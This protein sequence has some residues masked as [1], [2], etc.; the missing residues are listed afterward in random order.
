M[1]TIHVNWRISTRLKWKFH[2]SYLIKNGN[3]DCKIKFGKTTS[4]SEPFQVNHTFSNKRLDYKWIYLANIIVEELIMSSG[5]NVTKYFKLSSRTL[6]VFC[7]IFISRRLSIRT[8]THNCETLRYAKLHKFNART[9]DLI[10]RLPACQ[11]P[12]M[13]YNNAVWAVIC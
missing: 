11:V 5:N 4:K 7:L 1:S 3:V 9:S 10:L 12:A 8:S 6:F 2:Y 13:R